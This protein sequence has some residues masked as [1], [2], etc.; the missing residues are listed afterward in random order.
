MKISVALATLNEEKNLGA[1]LEAVRQLA[2]EIVIADEGSTDKTL[3]IARKYGAKIISTKHE[4]IFHITKQKAIDA[5]TGDWILQLDADEIVTPE[6]MSEIKNAISD[7]KYDG[8]W[9]PRK[10]K[11]LSQYL[12]KG[13]QYPDYTLRLYRKGKGKLPCLSVHEQA[14]VSGRVGY[15]KNNLLHHPF[16]NFTEYLNKANRYTDL[17]AVEYRSK[18]LPTSF[19]GLAKYC[20]LIPNY[21]FLNLLFRHQGFK[22]GFPG[23]IFALFSGIQ[24]TI[25]YTKYWEYSHAQRVN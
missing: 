8:Y 5:C 3:E 14:I 7:T 18:K 25:A 22:D 1:C 6:L 11:F 13:G 21:T 23:F 19:F 17:L 20:L 12:T 4:P 16:S 10:N 15:L 9:I 2:D 24:Q